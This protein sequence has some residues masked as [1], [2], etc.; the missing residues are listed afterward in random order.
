MTTTTGA[1]PISIVWTA[2]EQ[3]GKKVLPCH[4]EYYVNT[5]QI[6][7]GEFKGTS[8]SIV[9]YIEENSIEC[10]YRIGKGT[11]HCLVD[12]A[13]PFLL[14]NNNV[15]KVYEGARCVGELYVR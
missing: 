5:A 15:F 7:H 14:E 6:A 4:H 3:G 13:P 9:L 2:I 11:A 12:N 10:D 8:W 1:V